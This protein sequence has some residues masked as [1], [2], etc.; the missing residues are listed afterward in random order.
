MSLM[1]IFL[2]GNHYEV[3]IEKLQCDSDKYKV[4]SCHKPALCVCL[5]C[6]GSGDTDDVYKTIFQLL[7]A[8]SDNQHGFTGMGCGRDCGSGG[9]F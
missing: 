4:A 9:W 2:D 7:Y 3:Y 6:K 1:Q 8:D 5:K